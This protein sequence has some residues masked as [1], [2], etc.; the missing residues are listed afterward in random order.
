MFFHI[1]ENFSNYYSQSLKN[2]WSFEMIKLF[3]KHVWYWRN[4]NE[5]TY[6][7]EHNNYIDYLG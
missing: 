6:W 5:Y 2:F 3:H 7:D 1:S 4:S